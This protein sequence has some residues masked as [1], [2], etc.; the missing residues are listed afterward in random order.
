MLVADFT[1]QPPLAYW[2]ART[3]IQEQVAKEKEK[4]QMTVIGTVMNVST[5]ALAASMTCRKLR[6][7]THL[8]R[9]TEA[10]DCHYIRRPQ[11]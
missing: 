3:K 8:T 4:P 7:L 6:Q 10:W 5:Q 1:T 11:S 2:V 9:V